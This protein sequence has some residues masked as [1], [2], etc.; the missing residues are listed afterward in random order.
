[1]P[2]AFFAGAFRR[3]A[4]RSAVLWRDEESSYAALRTAVGDGL[5]LLEREGVPRGAVVSLEADFSPRAI[6]LLFALVEHRCIAVPLLAAGPGHDGL[7]ALAQVET[8]VRVGADDEARLETGPARADHPLLRRLKAAGRPGL[9]LFSSGSAGTSKAAVHDFVPLLEKFDRPRRA[10]RAI[11]LLQFDHIGG[12]NT[13]LHTLSN[14]GSLV[15][16]PD[17]SPDTV[18]RLVERFR[19]QLLPASPTFLNLL[20]LSNAH[21]RHD[22][23]S[24]ELITYGTEVMPDVTLRR[25]GAIFPNVRLLQ[26]YGLSEV[27]ILR[28]R[29]RSSDSLWV[30]LGGEGY[31]TRVVDGEL[32]IKAR[33]AMLGYLN[34]PSPFTEDGWLR[35]HDA[36]EVDGE[37]VRILGRRSES[38]N[39]GG[40]KVYPAEVEGVLARMSGVAE[41]AV[42]G[43]PNAITG[44][45]VRADVK[46][47]APEPLAA[48]RKRMVVFCRDQLAPF[49]VPQKVRL[50]EGT[51]AG[52]RLKKK[53]P[54]PGAPE[55]PNNNS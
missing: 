30:K 17:R 42:S 15:T 1:V 13:L 39:V 19:A 7:R 46:L 21:R 35:T 18:C 31:E 51:L 23:S 53:R 8:R 4:E 41:V 29:S 9:V 50:V 6:A 20:L 5:R 2:H 32:E 45:I 26:T 48:F 38:I 49:K 52:E 25:L 44:E 40:E 47:L 10:W 27:G 16:V 37:W 54:A 11:A 12:L 34:A 24:L 55:D 14:G 43:E 3:H 36:V 22:L 28:S 33:S